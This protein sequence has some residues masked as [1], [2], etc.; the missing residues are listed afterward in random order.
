MLAQ[1]MRIR[2][3]NKEVTNAI[4]AAT[5]RVATKNGI[6][7]VTI[8]AVAKEAK[9][10]VKVV[11]RRF[12]TDGDLMELYAGRLDDFLEACFTQ[13][14]ELP[15]DQYYLEVV[16]NFMERIDDY[17]EMRELILWELNEQTPESKIS[18]QKRDDSLARL[19]KQDLPKA[20]DGTKEE[21]LR[22]LI[23][24]A[25]AGVVYLTLLGQQSS[26]FGIEFYD[27]EGQNKVL[28]SLGQLLR[29]YTEERE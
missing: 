8:R 5:A 13:P 17:P 10:D 4:I 24:L 14:E 7:S 20:P 22:T 29:V 16:R 2:R 3:T 28:E 18:S 21:Q 23:I 6:S 1:I 15:R 19:I 9:M 25:A 27:E 11:Q 12:P 26:F